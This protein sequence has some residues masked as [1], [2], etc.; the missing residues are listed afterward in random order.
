MSFVYG[1]FFAGI[2]YCGLGT[3]KNFAGI[4]CR[5]QEGKMLNLQK[6]LLTK[7]SSYNI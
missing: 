2:C 3:L 6:T 1:N 5:K 7:I 4:K